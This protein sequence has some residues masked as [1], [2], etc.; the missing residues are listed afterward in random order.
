MPARERLI[1]LVR[2]PLPWILLLAL[3][4]RL[5]SAGH[6]RSTDDVVY[7]LAARDLVQG[8]FALQGSF[9]RLRMGIVLPVAGA[10]ALFGIRLWA[11]VLFPLLTSLGSIAVLYRLVDRSSGRWTASVASLFLAVSTQH[12][13]SGSE[14]FPDAPVGFWVLL[15]FLLL[16][17]GRD[18][19]RREWWY[20]A[21][22][23]CLYLGIAT[24][25]DA[26]KLI[27]AFVLWEAWVAWKRGFDRR[28][29]AWVAALLG[30]L[31]VD[32]LLLSILSEGVH[33]RYMEF[34][35]GM[36]GW[37]KSSAARNL[38]IWPMLK[39]LVSPFGAFGILFPAA[40]VGAIL[41]WNR[42]QLGAALWMAAWV[43]GPAL[44]VA[45]LYRIGDGRHHAMMSPFVAWFA[46]IAVAAVRSAIA[47]PVLV[48]SLALAGAVLF[49]FRLP[50]D[51]DAAYALL[52]DALKTREGPI[53]S[54][55]RTTPAMSLYYPE[56][57]VRD[58]SREQPQPPCWIID[59]PSM[60]AVDRDLYGRDPF[61]SLRTVPVEEIAVPWRGIP[62]LRELAAPLRR[63]RG[64]GT[65]RILL[66]RSSP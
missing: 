52:R 54:D 5:Q 60:R 59:H 23:L 53:Y 58:H 27:P 66:L 62:V 51:R 42:R 4:L 56:A 32:A 48:G 11:A 33:L 16:E 7:G 41:A 10:F 46:A 57:G 45:A 36:E 35:H 21:S 47:R 38:G 65:E 34:G 8:D 14:V 12:A 18:R 19:P 49:H 26:L 13:L 20:A 9:H 50:P 28:S 1:G 37:S 22:G 43:L 55:P 63:W 17:E 29:L 3:L 61:P 39:S 30:A 31:F 64:I 15:S 44:L 6:V 24:R 25:I 2:H 40:G